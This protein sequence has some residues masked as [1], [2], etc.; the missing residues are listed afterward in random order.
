MVYTIDS[1]N[2]KEI[3]KERARATTGRVLKRVELNISE[4][5]KKSEIKELI[6]EEFRI[7]EEVLSAFAKAEVFYSLRQKTSK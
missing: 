5:Q 4:E 1:K 7:L 3:L 2:L 6:P